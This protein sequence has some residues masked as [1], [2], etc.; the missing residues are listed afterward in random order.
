MTIGRYRRGTRTDFSGV[1]SRDF[2]FSVYIIVG[3]SGFSGHT[4]R[5]T[6]VPQ[7][8]V[9]VRIDVVHVFAVFADTSHTLY[10]HTRRQVCGL[11]VF[12]VVLVQVTLR[13]ED[14]RPVR[15]R[16]LEDPFATDRLIDLHRARVS[17][18]QAFFFGTDRTLRLR[19]VLPH[20][21]RP[22]PMEDAIVLAERFRSISPDN[23][24]PI[25]RDHTREIRTT[26]VVTIDRNGPLDRA[27]RTTRSDT[28]IGQHID[29][30]QFPA[31]MIVQV[32]RKFAVLARFDFLP[33][34][35]ADFLF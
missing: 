15:A 7:D 14:L 5:D 2:V 16:V 6:S 18:D 26:T 30:I 35:F 23:A 17:R 19:I 13:E 12:Q 10:F 27:E 34:V 21:Q 8:D 4:R 33:D 1:I 3:C 22:R 31:D 9:I 28:A 11:P 20:I 25:S 24:R 32:M 29:E